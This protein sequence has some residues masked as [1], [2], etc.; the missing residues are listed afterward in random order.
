[1]TVEFRPNQ[2]EIKKSINEMQSKLEVLMTRVNEVEEQVSDI[3][4]KLMARKEAEEE[5]KNN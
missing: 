1:M 4:D 5:E 3:E 2:A